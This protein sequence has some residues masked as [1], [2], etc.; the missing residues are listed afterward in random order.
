MMPY[1]HNNDGVDTAIMGRFGL[2]AWLLSTCYL[3]MTITMALAEN[4]PSVDSV[5]QSAPKACLKQVS[6]LLKSTPESSRRW[7][8]L[9]QY[10][11]ESLF[12]L[13]KFPRLKRESLALLEREPLPPVL[14]VRA[15]IYLAKSLIILSEK[16]SG[17]AHLHSAIEKLNHL[18][19]VVP[20]PLRLV[21]VANLYLYLNEYGKALQFLERLKEQYHQNRDPV[22]NMELYGNLSHA[23]R[24]LGKMECFIEYSEETLKWG[25]IEGNEQQ[26][27]VA[28]KNLGRAYKQVG[29][30]NEAKQAFKSGI[31]HAIT[32]GDRRLE[33]KLY[34]FMAEAQKQSG[35]HTKS[36]DYLSKVQQEL[37]MPGHQNRYVQLKGEL[38]R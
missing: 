25:M 22:F 18:N 11:L 33:H 19:E 7:L 3:T 17:E 35:D 24:N 2:L 27:G 38:V 28:Y 31:E 6:V 10:Q 13:E 16:K 34:L 29:R 4:E 15:E 23:C 21:D 12:L 1:K 9:K 32:S 26:I 5:C 36:L 14:E 8:T 37:L 20:N 30:F